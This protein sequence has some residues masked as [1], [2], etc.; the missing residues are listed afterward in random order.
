MIIVK[1]TILLTLIVAFGIY[2]FSGWCKKNK[3][4]AY[5]E[6][7]PF[8]AYILTVLAVIDCIGI[9]TSAVWFL[10]FYL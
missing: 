6:D 4:R 8:W 2:M 1:L 7:Y 3:F 10:F 9:F 5:I